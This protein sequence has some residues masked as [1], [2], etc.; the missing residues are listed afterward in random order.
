[1]ETFWWTYQEYQ[2]TPQWIISLYL[3]KKEVDYMNKK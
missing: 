1:M 2:E 3:E